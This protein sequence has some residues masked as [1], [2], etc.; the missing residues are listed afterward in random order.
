MFD[1]KTIRFY[2]KEASGYAA[3]TSVHSMDEP[4]DRLTKFLPSKALILDLGCGGGRDLANFSR[5][6]FNAIGL[7][8][9]SELAKIAGG[10]SGC[11]VVVGDLLQLPFAEG[12]FDAVW[13][14]ASLLHVRRS[15]IDRALDLVNDILVTGGLFFCSLKVG[16]GEVRTDDSRFFTYF[17]PSEW[18]KHLI[19]KG[20]ELVEKQLDELTA[21]DSGDRWMNTIA[22]SVR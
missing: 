21:F 19:R 1:Q 18:E 8:A 16:R 12:T 22:R 9:S 3:A 13:A 17:M 20:F 6:G 2:E 4:M 15:E 5:R 7:D 11:P 10:T 14:S